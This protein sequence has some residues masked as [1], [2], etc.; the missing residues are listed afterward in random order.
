MVGGA[1]GRRA[2]GRLRCSA[3][4]CET[5][6]G[7]RGGGWGTRARAGGAVRERAPKKG[8]QKSA[9]VVSSSSLLNMTKLRREESAGK[10]F[11]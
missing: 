6:G 4:R 5:S 10:A 3:W 7:G 9:R 11:I 8:S 2:S 1:G